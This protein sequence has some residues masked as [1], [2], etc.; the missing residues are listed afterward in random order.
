M[1]DNFQMLVDVETTAEEAEGLSH[2]V[3]DRFRKRGLITGME[4]SG[5][6]LGGMGYMPGPAVADSYQ[7][8]RHEGRFWELRTCGVE[9]KSGR[10]FNFWALGPVGE[11]FTC[12][13]CGTYMERNEFGDSFGKAVLDWWDQGGPGLL[14]CPACGKERSIAEWEHRPPLGFGNL[15]FRFW[16]WPPLDSPSWKIDIAAIVREV[17]GHKIVSTH[18]HV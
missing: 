7:P 2:S 13:E 16:N 3:L 6:V 10:N 5:C 12:S 8:G 9:S 14:P 4:I 15:S 1:S 18:G 17:T 11:G